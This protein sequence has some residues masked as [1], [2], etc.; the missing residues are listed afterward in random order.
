[1]L[2]ACMAFFVIGYRKLIYVS[3]DGMVKETH[4]WLSHH[5]ELLKWSEVKYITIMYKVGHAMVFLERDALGWK[6]LFTKE[7]IP[8]LREIFKKYLPPDIGINEINSR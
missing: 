6:V 8:E 5:R 7:Q 2:V 1:M 3:Q 4:T